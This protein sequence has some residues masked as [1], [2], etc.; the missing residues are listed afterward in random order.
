MSDELRKN[1]GTQV[2]TISADLGEMGSVDKIIKAIPEALMAR[3]SAVVAAAGS[4]V[5]DSASPEQIRHMM[6]IKKTV[7]PTLIDKLAPR[8][9]R[10]SAVILISSVSA[11]ADN[12]F[13]NRSF[14][15]ESNA[16]IQNYGRML[17]S[18]L[19][20][21]SPTTSVAVVYPGLVDTPGLRQ[22]FFASVD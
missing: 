11:F 5:S 13:P 19:I 21:E 3:L 16:A 8:L 9:T 22:I 6:A 7:T 12:G 17:R 1:Y 4:E 14:Y 10:N 20:R 15:A 18:R 2:V